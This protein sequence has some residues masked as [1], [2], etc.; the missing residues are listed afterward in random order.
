[1]ALKDF[2]MWPQRSAMQII[3]RH[4]IFKC[5]PNQDILWNAVFS[6]YTFLS[7][8]KLEFCVPFNSQGHVGTGPQHY[9]LWDSNPHRL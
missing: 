4:T 6:L 9:H 3:S 2:H 7:K 8:S 5:I 1:M